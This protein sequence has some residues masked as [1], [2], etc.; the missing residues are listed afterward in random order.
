VQ[1]GPLPLG[2]W[3]AVCISAA[4]LQTLT[5]KVR[6]PKTAGAEAEGEGFSADDTALVQVNFYT[7]PIPPPNSFPHHEGE[8]RGQVVTTQRDNI[9]MPLC[10]ALLF[11]LCLHTL[12]TT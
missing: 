12:K 6:D 1:Q 8:A 10:F 7:P 3:E 9:C 4:D 11:F 2:V 5:V